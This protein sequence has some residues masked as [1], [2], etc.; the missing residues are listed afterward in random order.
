MAQVNEEGPHKVDRYVGSR[1]RLRRVQ[2]GLSQGTLASRLGVS[3]QAVQKY[4]SGE[5][6]VSASRLYEIAEVL[7]VPPGFFFE[8]FPEMPSVEK[9]AAD[10]TP[11]EADPL[12]QRR[13]RSLIR[14]FYGIRDPA[15]R[16]D[17]LRLVN[18]LAGQS[19]T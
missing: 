8:G 5:I 13:V 4:E 3:F 10:A 7:E 14:G 12:D 16:A 2:R 1:I 15:V 6:R 9:L 18:K 11:P 19:D 17:I